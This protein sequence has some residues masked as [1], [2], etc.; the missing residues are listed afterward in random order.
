LGTWQEIP[1]YRRESLPAGFTLT[2]PLIITQQDTT[3]LVWPGDRLTVDRWG[4][5]LIETREG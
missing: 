1:V 2:G 4:N 5:L 3:T